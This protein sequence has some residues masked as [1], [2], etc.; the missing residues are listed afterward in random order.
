MIHLDKITVQHSPNCKKC[1]AKNVHI[2]NSYKRFN[3]F[4]ELEKY[5]SGISKKG[6]LNVYFCYK[7]VE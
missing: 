4:V 1:G 6:F 7:I 3:S 5:R 2:R